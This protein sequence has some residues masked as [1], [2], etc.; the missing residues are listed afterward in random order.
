MN[1]GF[2][3]HWYSMAIANPYDVLWNVIGFGGQMIFG[4]DL[5]IPQ[6]TPSTSRTV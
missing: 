5:G 3:A 1:F 4:V 2:M 6:Q